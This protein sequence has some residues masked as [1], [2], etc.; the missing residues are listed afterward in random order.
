M[1]GRLPPSATLREMR[2]MLE[3]EIVAQPASISISFAR[4]HAVVALSALADLEDEVGALEEARAA[5]DR[6]ARELAI[7][8]SEIERLRLQMIARDLVAAR[9]PAGYRS[10]GGNVVDLTEALRRERRDTGRPVGPE[11]GAA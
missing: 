1:A 3:A 11:G 10:S 6:L 7:A 4:T 5:A 8:H 9:I 2:L